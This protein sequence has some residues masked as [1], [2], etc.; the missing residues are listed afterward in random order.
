MREGMSDYEARAWST[1]LENERK[2]RDSLRT[3]AA[4]KVALATKHAGRQI[5]KIPGGEKV[6]ELGDE[7]VV[8][9]LDGGFK[10]VFLP[11]VR[12]TS[13]EKRVEKLHRKHQ[14]VGAESLFES[15][16][17]KDIDAGRP[18]LTIPFIGVIESGI[19]SVAVTGAAVSTTVTGGTSAGVAVAAVASD[20]VLSLALVGRAVAEVAVHYGYDPREPEE[21]LFLMG[22]LNYSM[23]SS[24]TSKTAA[25]ASLSRLTQQMMRRAT[26]NELGK[27]PLVQIIQQIFK[28]LGL[29]LV[30]KR[31]ASV[32][33]VAGIVIAAGLSFN[34]LHSA[35]EDA[36]RLYRARYL[37]EKYGLSWAE[38][39]V[40]PTPVVDAAEPDPGV[41]ATAVEIDGLLD[42]VV[43][44]GEEE[45]GDTP[46]SEAD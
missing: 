8:K 21:E 22:V 17:L 29:R 18:T 4:G 43:V 24:S 30:K 10:A 20:V 7:T 3:R 46:P 23:A 32:V 42:E 45:A 38:W 15:L 26:W 12:S 40:K 1:L 37:A 41:D 25:L 6:A 39:T 2:R 34:M 28:L 14:D 31:L 13:L 36:T 27:E 11:A 16:D 33:P 44:G 35:V 19:A 9:A 5:R